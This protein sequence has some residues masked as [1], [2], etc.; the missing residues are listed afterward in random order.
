M[1]LALSLEK[2]QNVDTIQVLQSIQL[3]IKTFDE[4]KVMKAYKVLENFDNNKSNQQSIYAMQGIFGKLD[5]SNFD[6]ED[7][8]QIIALLDSRKIE[9]ENKDLE[10]SYITSSVEGYRENQEFVDSIEIPE[11]VIITKEFKKILLSC[12][13]LASNKVLQARFKLFLDLIGEF[14]NLSPNTST[15]S[16]CKFINNATKP[17]LPPKRFTLLKS[18]TY[19]QSGINGDGKYLMGCEKRIYIRNSNGKLELYAYD[20]LRGLH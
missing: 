18:E 16:F 17:R 7:L 12:K 10:N 4:Q 9:V 11:C 1:N 8:L 5:Y 6:T 3:K 13:E 20:N 19:Q 14:G 15:Q 2:I